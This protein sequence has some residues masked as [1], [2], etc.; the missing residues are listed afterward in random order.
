MIRRYQ[1]N[2]IPIMIEILQKHLANTSYSK[3]SFDYGK[4]SEVL[5]GNVNNSLFFCNLYVTDDKISGAFVAT[6]ASPMFTKELIAYDTLFYVDPSQ[7]SLKT[8]TAL[9][10]SYIKWAKDRGVK[11]CCLSNS[12]GARVEQFERLANR[13]GFT[14]VGSIHHMEL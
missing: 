7:R 11:K 1:L 4:M 2:D 10:D 9:V 6:L 13:F 8:A 14:K 5:V 3:I 12:M